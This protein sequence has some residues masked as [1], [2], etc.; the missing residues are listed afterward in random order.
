MIT[1]NIQ[2]SEK[3]YP[4]FNLRQSRKANPASGY[5]ESSEV[6]ILVG[7]ALNLDLSNSK[8]LSI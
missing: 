1:L 2:L 8:Q 3:R 6:D 4:K 7:E 5:K